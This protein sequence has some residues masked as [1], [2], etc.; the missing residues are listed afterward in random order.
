MAKDYYN[1]L[2]VSEEASQ[3]DIKKAFRR[4]AKQ[5][6]PDRN[7]GDKN[8]ENRFKE[9]SEAYD[10]LGDAEKRKQ[11]DMMRRYGAYDPRYAQQ[12]GG[13][14][15]SQFQQTFR[16]EDLGGFG[17]FADIFSS[18]FGDEDIFSAN[19]PGRQARSRKGNDLALTLKIS[20]EESISGAQKTIALNKPE[21]C[22]VCGGSGAEPGTEQV[23]CPLCNGRGMVS[24]AQ[25]GFS[26]SRPC[27]KCLG[28]G[29]LP[30]KPCHNCGGA[31]QIKTR[32]RIKVNIPPGIEP[33]GKIRLKGMGNPGTNGGQNGDL[34]ITVD[35]E[36]NQQFERKGNDIYTRI[37][38]SYP[39]A[40]LG[41]K[42]PVKTLTRNINLTIPPGTSH[43]TMLRLKGQGLAVN[44]AHGDQLVE[45]QIAVPKDITPRQRELLEELAK[46][47]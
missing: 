46:T 7:K 41:A 32:K 25:G 31:G 16:F 28:K 35:V 14:D 39:Q 47:M 6:H 44:G 13:F 20:F 38:V 2:G 34:L 40:V 42:V 17:S 8:A 10:I 19:R 22:P 23:V 9:I 36:K 4:L 21:P 30:G 5:Y 24:S 15:P 12:G 43:G 33:G 18:I 45:I 1:V 11:Y 37:T 26:V 27:P 29:V 3:E